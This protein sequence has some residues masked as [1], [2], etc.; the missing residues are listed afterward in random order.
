[1]VQTHYQTQN[2][3]TNTNFEQSNVEY[4]EFWL[5]DPFI[6]DEN[7][8]STGGTISFNLGSISEDVL[9]D[10]RKQY[11]NGLPEDGG[12]AQT[13]STAFGKAPQ[14]QSLVYAF[15]TEGQWFR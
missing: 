9:K 5:L 10:G 1:M 11:E 7:A 13:Q 8:G 15:D 2:K 3:I 4:I 12:T 14:N 6:Y